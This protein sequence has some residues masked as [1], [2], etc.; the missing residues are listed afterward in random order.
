M[1]HRALVNK[2]SREREISSK[3]SY[4]FLSLTL[5]L[6]TRYAT[7][8]GGGGTTFFF[9]YLISFSKNDSFLLNLFLASP[10]ALKRE[11]AIEGTTTGFVSLKTPPSI[12]SKFFVVFLHGVPQSTTIE[13]GKYIE[14]DLWRAPLKQDQLNPF[15]R[16]Q[17]NHC[18]Y[19][20]RWHHRSPPPTVSFL[21]IRIYQSQ[22]GIYS[23]R[24]KTATNMKLSIDFLSA[25][26]R[27]Q[28]LIPPT[29]THPLSFSSLIV[30]SK[31][32]YFF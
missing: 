28:S 3:W 22:N 12:Y 11:I 30:S 19:S 13:G 2:Y 5:T 14:I 4:P 21:L 26:V 15:L 6:P 16:S 32:W 24:I 17:T 9:L 8:I 27:L 23:T 25:F 20:I 29:H 7:S 31:F 18:G 10:S 1:S